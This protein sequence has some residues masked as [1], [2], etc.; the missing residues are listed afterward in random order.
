MKA[1]KHLTCDQAFFFFQGRTRRT[2]LSS[3]ERYK[4]I[5]GRGHDLRLAS[6]KV[7]NN[8]AVVYVQSSLTAHNPCV[9]CSQL[10]WGDF[11]ARLRFARSTILE[12]K[13]GTTRKLESNGFH[14][15][16]ILI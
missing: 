15:H 11:H 14:N 12:E 6:I 3:R 7:E 2:R 1:G 16:S 8:G 4:G 5:I 10:G 9:F 13:W